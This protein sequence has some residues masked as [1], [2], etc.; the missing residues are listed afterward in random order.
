MHGYVFF[1]FCI[2]CVSSVGMFVFGFGESLAA[3]LWSG[4]F[5]LVGSFSMSLRITQLSITINDGGVYNQ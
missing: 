5:T 2:C 3:L 1:A 4:T